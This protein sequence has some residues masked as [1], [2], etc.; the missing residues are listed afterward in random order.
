MKTYGLIG[1]SLGHSFSKAYFEDKFRQL[2]ILNCEYRNFEIPEI[3][4]L[5]DL[6]KKHQSI[7][8]LNVTIPFKEAILPLLDELSNDAKTIGAVNCIAVKRSASEVKLIGH[9]TDW[10]GFFYSLKPLLNP[11]IKNTALVLGTGGASKAVCYALAQLGISF[12]L[13]SR[14][15]G[16]LHYRDLTKNIIQDHSLI[17]NT[18]P[19]GTF[20]DT[21]SCPYIPYDGIEKHHIA[22]DL[23]YNPEKSMFLNKCKEQGARIKNG[24]EMLI[25]QAEQSWEIWN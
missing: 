9:N 25:L 12:N 19:L 14:S 16:D 3:T 24:K 8:G 4:G 5:G 22:F 10:T 18:T 15:G 17:I 6:I 13:V 23:I 11:S 7:S 2:A 21:S 20:P 1:K